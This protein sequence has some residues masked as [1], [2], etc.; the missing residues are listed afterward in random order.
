METIIIL[1]ESSYNVGYVFLGPSIAC[2]LFWVV[3]LIIGG[4]DINRR[5]RESYGESRNK[6][7]RSANKVAD[8]IMPVKA[9][10]TINVSSKGINYS[11]E[12]GDKE[13]AM[14]NQICYRIAYGFLRPSPQA[15]KV[16][17]LSTPKDNQ[18]AATDEALRIAYQELGP[19]KMRKLWLY[20]NSKDVTSCPK[21][22]E[23]IKQLV[24]FVY[25][26]IREGGYIVELSDHQ[27][28]MRAALRS[29][30]ASDEDE[31]ALDMI[32]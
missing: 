13:G 26:E 10:K 32:L 27:N 18:L 11:I 1:S 22:L 15:W 23:S 4:F 5:D 3:K 8:A 17:R 24:E 29:I 7:S 12:I 28:D 21:T 6:Y 2:I 19:K 30:E 31:I 14:R 9:S 20:V 16:R 25:T